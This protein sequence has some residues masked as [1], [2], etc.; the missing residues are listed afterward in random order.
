MTEPTMDGVPVSL[1]PSRALRVEFTGSGSEYFRIW[2]VNLLLILVTI[3]LYLPFAKARRLRYFCGNTVVDGH[4]L[5]FHGDP[6]RMFRGFLLLA[7]LAGAYALAGH[8]SRMAGLVAFCLLA[9]MWPALWRSSLRFRLGN[10][11][12]RGLRFAFRGDLPGA[13]R[14]LLPI[15]LPALLLMLPQWLLDPQ[16]PEEALVGAGQFAAIA[17]LGLLSML[18]FY[19]LGFALIKRYQHGGYACADQCTRLDVPNGRFYALCF[20]GIGLYVLLM[21]LMGVLAAIMAA[22][23]GLGRPSGGLTQAT[24]IWLAIIFAIVYLL[25]LAA[26]GPWFTARTQNLIWS[27]T[28]SQ[29][30]RFESHLSVR[31][32]AGLTVV[33]WL[34]TAVTL[35]LYRP[36]AA[37]KTARL[38]LESMSLALDGEVETWVA[39]RGANEQDASGDA[40]GDFFGIDLG[41]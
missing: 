30:L 17:G 22:V 29:A 18:V 28:A 20:K 12:W 9:A 1:A 40:A 32:L 15:Y 23:V 25:G 11:S 7:V 5:A 3:G 26:I 33:N 34:L 41:L 27:G 36:F 14:A 4:A 39:Q 2:I 8:V 13:Y 19:P 37:V 10:T 21:V 24:T 6:W 35:G 38:R 31:A 16:H